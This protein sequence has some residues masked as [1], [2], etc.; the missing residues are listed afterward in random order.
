VVGWWGMVGVVGWWGWWGGKVVDLWRVLWWGGEVVGCG[1]V[2]VVGL[3]G[4]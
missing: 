1:G 4:R 3:W 2:C